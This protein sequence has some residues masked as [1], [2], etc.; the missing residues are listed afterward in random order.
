VIDLDGG[1]T[2]RAR[3]ARSG[4]VA[5]LGASARV[6]VTWRV[7]DGVLVGHAPGADPAAERRPS[8]MPVAGGK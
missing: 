1:M 3:T 5:N 7:E 2:V 8:P 6:V 4:A